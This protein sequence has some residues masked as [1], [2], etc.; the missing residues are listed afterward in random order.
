MDYII[1]FSDGNTISSSK[2][3]EICNKVLKN[4]KN[5][6]QEEARTYEMYEYIIKECANTL[7][8][9]HIEL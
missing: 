6:L 1:E 8:G 4:I 2:V 7:K 3:E 5:E 9:K